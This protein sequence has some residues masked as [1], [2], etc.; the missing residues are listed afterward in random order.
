M[1][2]V[3][4]TAEVF[5]ESWTITVWGPR[6][7]VPQELH[8]SMNSQETIS[9]PLCSRI[10]R[11][12][13]MPPEVSSKPYCPGSLI[14]RVLWHCWLI[15][16]HPLKTFASYPVIKGKV[17][18][19]WQSSPVLRI[20]FFSTLCQSVE[21]QAEITLKN[22]ADV[23]NLTCKDLMPSNWRTWRA[24]GKLRSTSSS[25]SR[26][27]CRQ[28]CRGQKP[29]GAAKKKITV[30]LPTSLC[31]SPKKW[32]AESV[33]SAERETGMCRGWLL[34][35]VRICSES[36]PLPLRSC[37]I[38]LF[39]MDMTPSFSN[40]RG[41]KETWNLP[42]FLSYPDLSLFFFFLIWKI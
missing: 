17:N 18:Y 39:Y 23:C 24:W 28:S 16:E 12:K 19:Y 5:G 6:G 30:L 26:A 21:I 25:R 20:L 4:G 40:F 32:T 42:T 15:G 9:W 38:S 34:Q 22:W 11:K 10:D 41:E 31:Q 1:K 29:D 36:S 14:L 37:F 35:E 8:E 3:D 13:T 7:D 2:G 27:G 33:I